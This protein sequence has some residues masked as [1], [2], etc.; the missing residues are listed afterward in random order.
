MPQKQTTSN[1]TLLKY[2]YDHQLSLDFIGLTLLFVSSYFGLMKS[3]LT[4]TLVFLYLSNKSYNLMVS[5]ESSVEE[6]KALLNYWFVFGSLIIIEHLLDYL[7]YYFPFSSVYYLFKPVFYIWV[8]SSKRNF[9]KVYKLIA[10]SVYPL[11]N[12]YLDTYCQ[13]AENAINHVSLRW[14]QLKNRLCQKF[15]KRVTKEVTNKLEKLD[16]LLEDDKS[17]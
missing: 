9:N 8:L 6:F 2:Y 3:F 11:V 4:N 15:H 7:L 13:V 12:S 16:E 5:K 1:N 10:E 17:K 14:T